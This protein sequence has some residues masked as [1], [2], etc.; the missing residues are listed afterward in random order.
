MRAL[1]WP[2]DVT[3]PVYAIARINRFD[4][5]RL[6]TSQRELDEFDR[7]HAAQPGFLDSV[8]VDLGHGRQ[9]ALNLWESEA[10]S[11][12]GLAVLG[13]HVARLLAPLMT[14]PSEFLGA[15]EVLTARSPLS[16]WNATTRD[17]GNDGGA[18]S[19]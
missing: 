7:L 18:Q 15:G 3:T 13:P 8:V 17:T 16:A 10:H 19:S 11:Q 14:A 12:A 5:V 6:T 9:L 4:P 1:A 2:H